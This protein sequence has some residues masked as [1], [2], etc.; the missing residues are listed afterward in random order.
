MLAATDFLQGLHANGKSTA[1][2]TEGDQ[3]ELETIIAGQY[4]RAATWAQNLLCFHY[5]NAARL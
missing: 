1:Q 5:G 3:N 4:D 2:L